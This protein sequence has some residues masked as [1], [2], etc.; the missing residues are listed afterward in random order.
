M[1]TPAIVSA[2]M[3]TANTASPATAAFDGA[4]VMTNGSPHAEISATTN[5]AWEGSFDG[6]KKV[7]AF[8]IYPYD[9]DATGSSPDCD[10]LVGAT[11]HIGTTLCFTATAT[12]FPAATA[13]AKVTITCAAAS[14]G[15]MLKVT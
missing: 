2:K 14:Y 7:T 15:T 10:D 3:T 5:D 1:G 6:C 13:C 8:D 4:V 11:F 12:E 9:I